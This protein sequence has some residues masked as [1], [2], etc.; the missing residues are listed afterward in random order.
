MSEEKVQPKPVTFT[1]DKERNFILD[2]NA[3]AKL[4]LL[5]SDEGLS[6]YHVE[7]DLLNMRPYAIRAFLWS[8]LVHEDN[9]LTPDFVGKHIDVNNIEGYAKKIYDTV[10]GE[11]SEE[12]KESDQTE[13][14][15]EVDNGKP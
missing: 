2:L 1:L 5:Y 7:R 14:Q 10:F 4:D 8:G 6:Y 3:Y 15:K 12:G 9:D 13:S 11:Q